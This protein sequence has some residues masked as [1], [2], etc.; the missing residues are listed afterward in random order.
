M[1]RIEWLAMV[2]PA[3]LVG[4]VA[5]GPSNEHDKLVAAPLRPAADPDLR[6]YRFT[7][8]VTENGGVTP[9]K[10]GAVI[11]VAITYDMR[12]KD[13][14]ADGKEYG[15]YE[16][17]KNAI[18]A[19]I[20]DLEFRSA[21]DVWAESGA[22]SYAEHVQVVAFDLDLP[23]GWEMDHHSG[24]KNSNSFGVLFQNA[25]SRNVLSGKALPDKVNLAD[26]KDTHKLRIDFF[27]GVKFPG[28][29]VKKRATV[30]ASVEEFEGVPP[31]KR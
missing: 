23:A 26:F 30:L 31:A 5:V 14:Q 15:R 4:A 13:L 18:S 24:D 3:I 22:F 7:A 2:C 16:S 17:K 9:F 29:E 20:G 25:P 8:R 27:S 28:G 11:K 12:G 19:R 10:V 21:G 6:T 1:R